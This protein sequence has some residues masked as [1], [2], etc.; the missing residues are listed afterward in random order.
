MQSHS[1]PHQYSSQLEKYTVGD[2]LLLWQNSRDFKTV[3]I[4]FMKYL[5]GALKR[6][7]LPE[8]LSQEEVNSESFHALCNRTPV[9][10]LQTALKIFDN[11]F[12]DAVSRGETAQSTRKN[13]RSALRRFLSWIERQVWWQCLFHN[14]DVIISPPPVKLP[15]KPGTGGELSLYGLLITDLPNCILEE[16]EE[17]RQFRLTGT[18]VLSESA[19]EEKSQKTRVRR[20]KVVP[21][22]PSTFEGNQQRILRFLGWY[23]EYHW[24]DQKQGGHIENLIQLLTEIPL[25]SSLYSR[26]NF[27]INRYFNFLFFIRENLLSGLKLELLTNIDLLDEYVYWAIDNRGI[28]YATG[29]H[30]AD[31][32]IAIAKWLNYEKSAR[33]NWSDI[34]LI[35]DLQDLRNEYS[36]DY[37]EQKKRTR[38]EK[39]AAKKLTHEEVEKVADYLRQCCAPYIG[40]DSQIHNCRKRSIAEITRQWQSYLFIKILVYCPVRQEEIRN[41]VL[42]ETL[43]RKEDADGKPYYEAYFCEHKRSNTSEDRHYKLPDVLTKDLDLWIYKW[44]PLIQDMIQT[45]EGWAAFW[46]HKLEEIDKIHQ[47]LDL[48]KQGVINARVKREPRKYIQGLERTLRGKKRRISGWQTGKNNFEEYNHVFFMFGKRG[49]EAFGKPFSRDNF[50]EVVTRAIAKATQALF[51]EPKWTNPHALRNIAEKHIRQLGKTDIAE[52]FG[53]FIGH[54]EKMGDEYAEQLTSEYE[55][56]ENITDTWWMEE[57]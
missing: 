30:F 8:I 15:K 19:L 38:A 55:L 48:A 5:N 2:A 47:R 35:L 22:K 27:F 46:G 21:V 32:A 28:S 43:L 7:V 52:H 50:W 54:S 18:K 20:P 25:R 6:Y 51:G 42:G 3:S 4:H 13:Y 14:S 11:R 1:L 57:E 49:I 23:V 34:Q 29:K 45:E 31:T 17:F 41:Y 36:E 37:E 40:K 12:A 56:T 10:K 9:V 53:I 44:K 39:W 33:R 26:N 24:L 16:L